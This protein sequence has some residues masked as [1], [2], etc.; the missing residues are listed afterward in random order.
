VAVRSHR[1]S[2]DDEGFSLIEVLVALGLGV[3]LVTSVA[4]LFALATMSNVA[5]RARTEAALLAE[6]KLEELRELS[7]G[8]DRAGGPATD[9]A[10]DTTGDV[11]AGGGV[12]LT[13][14]GSVDSTV[15]SYSDYVDRFGHRTDAAR[16]AFVRRWSIQPLASNPGNAIVIRVAVIRPADKTA[17]H[18]LAVRT[19]K[20]R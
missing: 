9:V 10:S 2:H 8:F 14:G 15:A 6:E 4:Q 20:A 16:A 17:L 11:F 3:I 7:F 12:G 18:L 5:A 19:R 13:P 1:R